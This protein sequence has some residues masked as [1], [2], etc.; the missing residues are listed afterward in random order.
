MQANTNN[1]IW[2][3]LQTTGSKDEPDIV[4]YAHIVTDITTWNSEHNDT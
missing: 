4:F 2:A 3:L 1:A